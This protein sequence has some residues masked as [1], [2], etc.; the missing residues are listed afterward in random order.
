VN[1]L[2]GLPDERR[3][4]SGFKHVVDEHNTEASSVAL[5]GDRCRLTRLP[6]LPLTK[7]FSHFYIA[8]RVRGDPL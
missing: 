2:Q 7:I 3:I 5:C 1:R 4:D 8:A 6:M